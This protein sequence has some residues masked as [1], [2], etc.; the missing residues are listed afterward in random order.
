MEHVY[1][2]RCKTEEYDASYFKSLVD[3][4]KDFDQEV[5]KTAGKAEATV[6]QAD[7]LS[8]IKEPYFLHRMKEITVPSSAM[9]LR[10]VRFALSSQCRRV[11]E[12]KA[13][14]GILL[15]V[16]PADIVGL[17]SVVSPEETIFT[18]KVYEPF[19]YV[20]ASR[21]S[22]KVS[23]EIQILGNQMLTVLRD[24]IRCE[25]G[26]FLDVS[27]NP[28][29]DAE[30]EEFIDSGFIFVDDT[31][32]NDTRKPA[33]LDYSQ[34]LL[35]WTKKRDYFKPLTTAIMEETRLRDLNFKL[36]FPYVFQHYGNCE[37]LL[38]FS[39]VRLVSKT[40]LN[41][42]VLFPIIKQLALKG[43]YCFVCGLNEA[44]YAVVGS[45]D[46]I[47]D[48]SQLCHQCLVM[49]HYKDGQKFGEFQ[50]FRL[51]R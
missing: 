19:K 44:L 18:V 12:T 28:E 30:Y 26:P 13:R 36:G 31:F 2:Q 11:Q 39:D 37:H 48:P 38:V 24:N 25:V 3:D 4:L 14:L 1:K 49:Y 5:S 43:S 6:K 22:P 9:S 46:H 42:A 40:E 32:Y 7:D 21:K 16:S 20:C 29:K 17:Q 34:V 15:D 35:H 23:Q 50:A 27:E 10:C 8:E 41:S 33:C 51:K 45:S 47:Q